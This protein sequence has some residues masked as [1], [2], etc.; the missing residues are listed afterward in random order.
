MRGM[1]F[2]ALGG[3][4]FMSLPELNMVLV[5]NAS[6]FK[7][8]S[9]VGGATR[10]AASPLS[11][12]SG[13]AFQPATGALYIADRGSNRVLA[14]WP[15][16]RTLTVVAGTGAAGA[17]DGAASAATF[18]APTGLALDATGA[19]YVTDSVG[20]RVRRIAA[21]VVVTIAGNG[22]VG[23]ADGPGSAACFRAPR[24]LAVSPDGHTV[25]VAD[26][27]NNRLRQLTYDALYRVYGVSTL[28]GGGSWTSRV[29]GY[30]AAASFNQPLAVALGANGTLTVADYG[31][32][33]LRAV[34]P[35][36]FVSTVVLDASG[37][38]P[39]GRPL[40]VADGGALLTLVSST[41]TDAYAVRRVVASPPPSPPQPP[42]LIR[43]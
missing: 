14:W 43:G 7:R 18:S 15:T 35:A 19:L 26:T 17:A 31:N 34:S 1:A 22:S 23:Y 33:A 6:T 39:P 28:A 20:A 37:S 38:L 24:G 36:G 29:D 21:G 2:D 41:L 4:L 42:L 13:L 40:G 3:R 10:Y 25:T 12:P 16:N 32:A 30:A 27:G 5:L 8:L 9:S 11:A